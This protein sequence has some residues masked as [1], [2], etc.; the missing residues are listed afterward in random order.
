MNYRPDNANFV[1]SLLPGHGPQGL[2]T[3]DKDG[4]ATVAAVIATLSALARLMHDISGNAKDL[5][6]LIRKMSASIQDIR[7][8]I[9]RI[10]K[11][12]DR[13]P[14]VIEE[15]VEQGFAQYVDNQLRALVL[16]YLEVKASPNLDPAM[17]KDRLM[18]VYNLISQQ[19]R[20]IMGYGVPAAS[21]IALTMPIEDDCAR[22]LNVDKAFRKA[23]VQTLAQFFSQVL[24]GNSEIP[25]PDSIE[26]Y[27]ASASSLHQKIT[28]YVAYLDSS[29]KG[30]Q[31]TWSSPWQ[32]VIGGYK[33]DHFRT[34]R[35]TNY[36]ATV[37]GDSTTGYNYQETSSSESYTEPVGSSSR[38]AFAPGIVHAV[39]ADDFVIAD[40]DLFRK[41]LIA[42]RADVEYANEVLKAQRQLLE[43]LQGVT[44]I[45]DIYA[46]A[47]SRAKEKMTAL[48]NG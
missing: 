43:N 20:V 5:E 28:G 19:S 8:S 3:Y 23:A 1:W 46:S 44:Q 41:D 16:M 45:R 26:G 25:K 12:L 6:N 39:A 17:M 34:C 32:C 47:L 30:R 22:M 18:Y 27:I 37:T 35:R 38:L 7:D 40:T 29:F 42:Q 13:L 33:N 2:P 9:R 21:V 31:R 36:Q 15:K 48:A 14:L 11:F 4:G 10:E 24:T